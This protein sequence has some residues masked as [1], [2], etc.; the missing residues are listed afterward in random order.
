MVKKAVWCF[1]FFLKQGRTDLLYY[2][3]I[4]EKNLKMTPFP[5]MLVVSPVHSRRKIPS[6]GRIW[7][8]LLYVLYFIIFCK[9]NKSI[10]CG[11]LQGIIIFVFRSLDFFLYAHIPLLL[12]MCCAGMITLRSSAVQLGLP[13]GLHF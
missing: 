4:K 7:K 3:N 5:K 12:L 6:N 1:F 9:T 10:F 2:H 13:A 11:L 8:T